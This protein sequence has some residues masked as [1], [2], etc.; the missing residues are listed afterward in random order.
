M[1]QL[2]CS[3][4]TEQLALL[5]GCVNGCMVRNGPPSRASRFCALQG[6]FVLYGRE[7]T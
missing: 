2:L 3:S 4:P 6:S 1:R 7:E 5:A